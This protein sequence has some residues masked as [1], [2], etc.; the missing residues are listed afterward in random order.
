M[1]NEPDKLYHAILP[2]FATEIGAA[3]PGDISFLHAAGED[4]DDADDDEEDEDDEEFEDDD[5]IDEDEDY[6]EE[7]EEDEEGEEVEEE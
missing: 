6:D 4:A 1:R 3:T 2:W 7:N 5:A